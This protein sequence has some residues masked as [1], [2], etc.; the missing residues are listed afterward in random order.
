MSPEGGVDTLLPVPPPNAAH[1]TPARRLRKAEGRQSARNQGLRTDTAVGP[2]TSFCLVIL[3]W[4]RTSCNLE[5]E[6]V[7]IRVNQDKK[8]PVPADT[9]DSAA[10]ATQASKGEWESWPLVCP[11]PHPW[12]R[13]APGE[14]TWEGS[15]ATPPRSNRDTLL[16]CPRKLSG[17]PT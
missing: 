12:A 1:G 7:Q 4:S 10:P 9:S 15:T 14:A 5:R 2:G 6:Q 16:R 13:V 8:W 3:T 17:A 11:Y